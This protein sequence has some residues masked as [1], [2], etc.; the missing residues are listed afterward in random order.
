[1]QETMNTQATTQHAKP[2]EP[3]VRAKVSEELTSLRDELSRTAH[4]MRTKTK[5]ASAEIQETRKSLEQEVKRF[6]AEVDQAV[7]RTREDLVKVGKDLR[8][9]FQKLADQ[10]ALPSN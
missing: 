4:E 2:S 1:M 9:R 3:S 5:D 10:I 8:T 6:S 7:E